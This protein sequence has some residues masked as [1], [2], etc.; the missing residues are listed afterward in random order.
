M[1]GEGKAEEG[2]GAL[3]PFRRKREWDISGTVN[4]EVQLE[5]LLLT[6][7]AQQA[8]ILDTFQKNAKK[9]R[10]YRFL[11]GFLISILVLFL[12]TIPVS[13]LMIARDTAITEGNLYTTFN[14]TTA[15]LAGYY[16]LL[17]GAYLSFVMIMTASFFKGESLR[18]LRYF[19]ISRSSMAWIVAFTFIRPHV[20]PLCVTFLALPVAGTLVTG[21]GKFLVASLVCN[22]VM[23]V[24]ILAVMVVMA[25]VIVN[26]VFRESRSTVNTVV[27]VAFTSLYLLFTFSIF[28]F[29]GPFLAWVS[30]LFVEDPSSIPDQGMLVV[31]ALVPF[32]FAPASLMSLSLFPTG[33]GATRVASVVGV[34]L[35]M[36][37]TFWL[38]LR[39]GRSFL[40]VAYQREGAQMAERREHLAPSKLVLDPVP[41][42]EA[43]TRSSLTMVTRDLSRLMMLLLALIMPLMWG[44]MY[45]T[46]GEEMAVLGLGVAMAYMG[47]MPDMMNQAFAGTEM[48]MG[49]V[50]S[51]LPYRNWD[52][53]R[54]RRRLISAFM[55]VPLLVMLVFFQG[56]YGIPGEFVWYF[57][58]A[59][60]FMVFLATLYLVMYSFLF[61]K[62]NENYTLFEV[63]IGHR[64]GKRIILVIEPATLIMILYV[65]IAV[66]I[67]L[68][69]ASWVGP[70]TFL[71]IFNILMVVLSDLMARKQFKGPIPWDDAS[72]PTASPE[73]A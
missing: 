16:L 55:V 72:R 58:S 30:S 62:V 10:R 48:K 64:I 34:L 7:G 11:Q 9:I 51:S 8:Q 59:F 71:W 21:S 57:L 69:A 25:E 54:A 53:F 67:G 23:V 73:P 18:W 52:L 32:P 29:L 63:N 35:F 39:A 27:R 4:E 20:L 12:T 14:A 22:A 49:G 42:V 40:R 47:L 3:S 19:P 33:L 46:M 44:F 24:F 43:F 6:A 1:T 45:M 60:P 5:A 13:G 2:L 41:P 61:G 31:M 28:I 17:M 56:R 36:A 15:A 68:I 37:L 66:Y 65:G 50:L 38:S 26:R 70:V